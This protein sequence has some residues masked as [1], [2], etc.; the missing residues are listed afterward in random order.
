M[1]GEQGHTVYALPCY[2][3]EDG[4]SRGDSRRLNCLSSRV[5]RRWAVVRRRLVPILRGQ[6]NPVSTYDHTKTEVY[7]D[8]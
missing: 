2:R 6:C 4:D 7:N 1:A 8:H 3:L 5:T